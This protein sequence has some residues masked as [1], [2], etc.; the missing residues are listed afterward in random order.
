MLKREDQYVLIDTQNQYDSGVYAQIHT[1][2]KI[3]CPNKRQEITTVKSVTPRDPGLCP[4]CRKGKH[5]SNECKLVIDVEGK[6]LPNH[7]RNRQRALRLR[8]HKCMEP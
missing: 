6:M 8:A 4:K 1:V 3:K 7:L 2:A 5:W